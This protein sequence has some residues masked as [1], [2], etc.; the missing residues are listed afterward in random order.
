MSVPEPY[1]PSEIPVNEEEELRGPTHPDAEGDYLS[2]AANWLT[3]AEQNTQTWQDFRVGMQDR[4]DARMTVTV[5]ARL[6]ELNIAMAN[7]CGGYQ[8]RQRYAAVPQRYAAPMMPPE[9][10]AAMAADVEREKGIRLIGGMDPEPESSDG[11]LWIDVEP[12]GPD[13][14]PYLYKL[15]PDRWVWAR[16]HAQALRHRENSAIGGAWYKVVGAHTVRRPTD[17]ERT[18]FYAMARLAEPAPE[19]PCSCCASGLFSASAVHDEICGDCGHA[20]PAHY[21][22]EKDYAPTPPEAACTEFDSGDN[23]ANPI[24]RSSICERCGA[25]AQAHIQVGLRNLADVGVDAPPP[26]PVRH[27][28]DEPPFSLTAFPENRDVLRMWVRG[29]TATELD[30]LLEEVQWA[31]ELH[32]ADAKAQYDRK[33]RARRGGVDQWRG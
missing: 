15:G 4:T 23:G 3:L 2:A 13:R 28:Q 1:E 6:A 22:P 25:S 32:P 31:R 27:V 26:I 21:M 24:T 7:A 29:R 19:Q 5:F 10:K 18:A 17:E 9:M 20:G 33:R 16:S 30:D 12:P 11:D 14:N 8:Y